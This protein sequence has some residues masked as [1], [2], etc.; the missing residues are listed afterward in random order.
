M[1]KFTPAKHMQKLKKLRSDSE[2][3]LVEL[4]ARKAGLE[5]VDLTMMPINTDALK[6]I[7]EDR[8][9]LAGIASFNLMGKKVHI[10]VRSP[11]PTLTKEEIKRLEDKQYEVIVYMA[12]KKSIERAWTRYGDI[13]YAVKTEKGIIDISSADIQDVLNQ[14]KTL[15]SAKEIISQTLNAR[16]AYRISKVIELILFSA[17]SLGASDVHI[18]TSEDS[19]KVR[20][21]LDGILTSIVDFDL[22]TYN[23]ILQRIKLTAGLKINIKSNAQDGRFTIK[24]VDSDI[25]I[26][27]ST[28]P[29][30]YG[31]SIVMSI[32][33]PN[34]ISVPL[35][36]LGMLPYFLKMM[37]EMVEKPNGMIINTGPT[38][39]GK[40][41]TLFALLKKIISPDIKIITIEDPIEYHVAGVTQT[42]V[43]KEK[44]YTFLS[45]LRSV[46]RQDPDVIMVGEIRDNETAAIAINSALTGH[47]VLSTL[48]TNSAAGAFPRFLDLGIDPKILATAINVILA[49]RLVRKL[50]VHCKKPINLFSEKN[51]RKGEVIKKIFHSIDNKERY[52]EKSKEYTIS[53]AIGCEKCNMTGYKGRVAIVEA[54][55]MDRGLEDLLKTKPTEREIVAETRRQGILNMKEDGIIKIIRGDISFE[56]L[57]RVIE[58]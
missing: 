41:T 54:V 30:A 14:I 47:L 6:L 4:Y 37:I 8:A 11:L 34:A 7:P 58:L 10:A 22:A 24:M 25:E 3:N 45:G 50:C 31:E 1:I 13:S 5:Y 55:L 23:R 19:A 15:K 49:Q 18:E 26:R 42:Q 21:R 2:E 29:D 20:F 32:L 53:E 38:G 17:Y 43:N 44:G 27:T 35:E 36:D 33:A 12:S 28:L 52:L 40:T 57:S 16:Q 39:S 46:L 9:R 51:I 56:E 48:H